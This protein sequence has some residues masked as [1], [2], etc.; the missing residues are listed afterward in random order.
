[1]DKLPSRFLPNN[2]LNKKKKNLEGGLE[3]ARTRGGDIFI[4]RYEE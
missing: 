1:M 2:I 3:N 4:F